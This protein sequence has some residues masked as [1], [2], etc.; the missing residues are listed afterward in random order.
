M[1]LRE[2]NGK[3]EL[4]YEPE[5][6]VEDID[7]LAR[8]LKHKNL[9]PLLE[10]FDGIY[11]I[12]AGGTVF[13]VCLHYRLGL[14]LLL[15]PTKRSIIAEDIVDSGKTILPYIER[16][17]FCVSLF[18]NPSSICE[19]SMWRREKENNI[20]VRFALWEGDEDLPEISTNYKSPWGETEDSNV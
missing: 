4:V 11:G 20:W 9:R 19:P 12:P 14:P 18:Y 13:A 3:Q 1:Y 7:F 2:R 16:G 10:P 8:K 6:T 17:M 5:E 15:A